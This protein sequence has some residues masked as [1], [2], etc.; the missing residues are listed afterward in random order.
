MLAMRNHWLQ[1]LHL[2]LWRWIRRL[3][4]P[5]IYAN[6]VIGAQSEGIYVSLDGCPTNTVRANIVKRLLDDGPEPGISIQ[7]GH[8]Q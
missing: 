8:E 7:G 5:P 4:P 2:A 1:C 6:K 3:E